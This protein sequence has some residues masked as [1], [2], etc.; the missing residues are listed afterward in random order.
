MLQP[1]LKKNQEYMQKLFFTKKKKKKSPIFVYFQA[2]SF[3]RD[4]FSTERFKNPIFI[5]PV[6][7]LYFFLRLYYSS[8]IT[9]IILLLLLISVILL[10]RLFFLFFG[11]IVE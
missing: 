2:A 4:F 9:F 8:R 11:T 6:T 7:Q 1:S 5:I 3:L 10:F